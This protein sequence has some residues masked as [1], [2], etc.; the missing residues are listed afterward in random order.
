MEWQQKDQ[1]WL[2]QA[3]IEDL[4]WAWIVVSIAWIILLITG[5]SHTSTLH[6][7]TNDSNWLAT[8]Q[9]LSY[10]LSAWETMIVAMMLPSVLPVARLF[11]RLNHRQP[12]CQSA[13]VAFLAGYLTIWTGFAICA[14]FAD[15]VLRSIFHCI[16]PWISQYLPIVLSFDLR[17]GAVSIAV[18]LFQF[19]PI[20]ETCLRGCRQSAMFIAQYYDRGWKSGLNLGIQHGLY[21]LGCCFALMV[22]MGVIGIHDLRWML[23]FTA[24]MTVERLWKFGEWIADWVGIGFIVLGLLSLFGINVFS[25]I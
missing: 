7:H 17:I 19:T 14:V 15:I 2:R 18:G 4:G 5:Y 22:E 3:L 8:V 10:S 25:L 24:I 23:V 11:T 9:H 13:Q 12:D 6:S 16:H 21:C 20:K 1:E